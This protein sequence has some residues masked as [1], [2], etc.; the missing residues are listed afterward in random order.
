MAEAN[1]ST[2]NAMCELGTGLEGISLGEDDVNA[3]ALG[4]GDLAAMDPKSTTTVEDKSDVPEWKVDNDYSHYRPLDHSKKD[5]RLV[6]IAPGSFDDPLHCTLT[7]HSYP[8]ADIKFESLSYCWGDLKDTTRITLRHEYEGVTN[9]KSHLV[10]DDEQV[11]NVTKNLA[12]AL[13]Y[14]RL[15][16]KSRVIWIDA[17]CINQGSIRERNYAIPFMVDVYKSTGCVIVFL[18]E[19]RQSE[20][21]QGMWD[22]LDMLNKAVKKAEVKP[23]W[24]HPDID[25]ALD[26]IKI[27]R[28]DKT[29]DS[30]VSLFK[31]HMSLIFG[32]FFNR[33]PWFK[34][35]WVIQEVMNARKAVVYCGRRQ[36]D[37]LDILVMLCWA[38]K[39][40]RSYVGGWTASHPYDELPPFL[41]TLLHAAR[42][43][44]IDRPTRLPLLDVVS[45]GRAFKATDSRDKIFALLSFGEETHDISGLPPRL[46]PDYGKTA[47]D[48]W[49]D[50]TRQWIIDHQSL[51]I[52]G[53]MREKVDRNNQVATKTVYLTQTS[54][55]ES[56]KSSSDSTAELPPSGHP[57][58]AIWH[59]EHP[60]SA[61]KAL[62]RLQ[63]AIANCSVAFHIDIL[64]NPKD[65]NVLSIPGIIINQ[66][67][68]VQWAFKRWTYVE[69]DMRQFN[70]NKTPPVSIES[71]V[72]VAWGILIGAI[73]ELADDGPKQIAFSTGSGVM[74]EAYPN[75]SSLIQAFVEALICRRFSKTWFVRDMPMSLDP[76]QS[77]KLTGSERAELETLAHFAAHWAKGCDPD[78]NWIPSVWAERLRPLVK[79]GD[80][81]RFTEM[82]EYAE[83]RCFFKT[84]RAGFGICP[85]GTHVGDFVASL[86]GGSTPFI[87]RPLDI[88]DGCVSHFRLIGECYLHDLDIR[89]VTQAAVARGD[90]DTFHI[91]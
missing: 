45:K 82:C 12:I 63:N 59:A 44:E 56:Q 43:G 5:I 13:K 69:D 87:L 51:D 48:V 65:P 57:S 58:W 89:R 88:K 38:A 77:D 71:G 83:G 19:E 80:S 81:R 34:R 11:F 40:S 22:L 54:D 70:H 49:R 9:S 15:E 78:M 84:K 52:I 72:S 86:A 85:Q 6:T 39:S 18:G 46:K 75:G 30:D 42:H 79:H 16:D 21:F 53:I 31:M 10:R 66:I 73:K 17:L 1:L 91:V 2:D 50:L 64:D 20:H 4:K 32:E 67:T 8:W 60:V 55:Q 25:K 37:W 7:R 74:I 62:F 23:L 36:R 61:A 26:E 35:V 3:G 41:W 33:F 47:S 90:T 24:Q 29:E 28:K 14:L 27:T 76:D 68:S